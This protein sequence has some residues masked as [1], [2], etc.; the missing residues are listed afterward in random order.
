[1]ILNHLSAGEHVVTVHFVSE[2]CANAQTS[3]IFEIPEESGLEVSIL[4]QTQTICG[5]STGMVTLEVNPAGSYTLSSVS[6]IVNGMTV[7]SLPAGIHTIV[8]RS[9]NGCEGE[10]TVVISNANMAGTVTATGLSA[11]CEGQ[12]S[13]TIAVTG[14]VTEIKV[15][16]ELISGAGTYMAGAGIHYVEYKDASNCI[17]YDTFAITATT[18]MS[19]S[20]VSSDGD[21]QSD[22]FSLDIVITGGTAPYIINGTVSNSGMLTIDSLLPGHITINVED[23]QGC[24]QAFEDVVAG[25]CAI[26][27]GI[28]V[29]SSLVEGSDCDTATGRVTVTAAGVSPGATVMYSINN[30]SYQAGNIFTGLTAGVYSVRALMT[31]GVDSCYAEVTV[32]VNNKTVSG[33]EIDIEV[34]NIY[35]VTCIGGSNGHATINVT[36]T[37]T[38]VELDGTTITNGT[39]ISN[40][41]AGTHAV[42]VHFTSAEC[43]DGQISTLFTIPE[44]SGIE[45]SITSQTNTTCGNATGSVTLGAIPVGLYTLSSVSGIVNGMTVSSLPAGIHTIRVRNANG[46]EEEVTAVI[47]N[48]DMTGTVTATGISAACEGEGTYTI[49]VTGTVAEIKV[50]GELISGAGTY[51][52]GA[53][54]HYV[55]YKDT[56]GCIG[57]DTFAIAATTPVSLSYAVSEGDCLSE[58]LRIDVVV[59]G[60][61]APYVINGITSASGLIT[62]TD[63]SAGHVTVMVEDSYQCVEVFEFDVY[64]GR[65]VITTPTGIVDTI[66]SGATFEYVPQTDVPGAAFIW[67]RYAQPGILE[68]YSSGT[69]AIEEALTNETDIPITVTYEYI[70]LGTGA[71]SVPDTVLVEVI[72]NPVSLLQLSHYPPD[73][74]AIVLGTPITIRAD[75]MGA[76]VRSYGFDYGNG[77]MPMIGIL[78]EY[79]IVD[80]IAGV[81]N[82]VEVVIINE[83]GCETQGVERFMATYALPNTITPKS[84]ENNR[85]LNG[86]NLQVFNRWG[87]ELYKGD[88]GWDGT[89]KGAYV[90][91]GTYFYVVKY[92][93]DG[94][95]IEVKNTVYVK[96]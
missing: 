17:G 48:T 81:Y 66:C 18:P 33:N 89:Y 35:P 62:L 91:S 44:G 4:S 32:L 75:G 26:D 11:A 12:G 78:N 57:Y 28:F 14:T 60:G 52:A 50:D 40:L 80:F 49:A 58:D 5:N 67:T 46:C 21:C 10:I 38:S 37:Y 6:G 13:Y 92:E 27:C 84:G 2:G 82:E 3:T 41:S 68:G 74:S 30:G 9:S 76:P 8:V 51:T 87:S 42:T 96:Y 43:P 20:Y 25:Y 94:K 31:L 86:Y 85:L 16:G 15:D 88:E 45:V 53:G 59:T 22:A 54:I 65:P 64:I 79:P 39:T 34:T 36:G 73:G 83:Y 69:G 56:S 23:S 63:M 70:I 72:V 95:L 7:S 19:L 61:A 24:G 1:M 90:A 93:Q 71:C 77:I 47:S 55:E 29:L